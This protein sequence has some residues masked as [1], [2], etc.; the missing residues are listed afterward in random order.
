[1]GD[2]Y[3]LQSSAFETY[4]EKRE[5]FSNAVALV[6]TALCFFKDAFSDAEFHN[7]ARVNW[8]V[9]LGPFLQDLAVIY[10]DRIHRFKRDLSPDFDN[11]RE[12]DDDYAAFDLSV[13]SLNFNRNLDRV[14][15][16]TRTWEGSS[17]D[18]QWNKPNG[19]QGGQAFILP[20]PIYD[21]ESNS[22]RQLPVL[23]E[24]WASKVK[25]YLAQFF[26]WII[27]DPIAVYDTNSLGRI[28][29][30]WVFYFSRGT[31]IPFSWLEALITPLPRLKV[32]PNEIRARLL[33][34][35]D[36]SEQFSKRFLVLAICLLPKSYLEDYSYRRRELAALCD[37][38]PTA[39][40]VDGRHY[41]DD[42]LKI[43]MARWSTAGT[44]LLIGQHGMLD[45]LEEFVSLTH[46]DL[47]IANRYFT[48]GT[49]SPNNRNAIGW[50]S[51]R[52]SRTLKK[53]TRKNI[54]KSKILYV[55]RSI[56]SVQRGT[57]WDTPM[58]SERLRSGRHRICELL[59]GD[60]IGDWLVRPRGGDIWGDGANSVASFE[61]YGFDIDSTTEVAEAFSSARLV[62]FE[63]ISTGFA[64]CLACDVPTILF[65]HR[66]T[67]EEFEGYEGEKAAFFRILE[68]SGLVIYNAEDLIALSKLDSYEWWNEP[69]RI[70]IR[71]QIA[72][73]YAR[74]RLDYPFAISDLI[75]SA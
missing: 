30:I 2:D 24:R 26:F 63:S 39:F 36:N 17:T 58:D 11:L 31:L 61:E 51:T 53:M 19:G 10:L 6:E 14:L 54:I 12:P 29:R 20:N 27:R 68:T 28:D 9:I 66:K 13:S 46:H 69:H 7:D 32:S 25:R 47:S 35:L 57:I 33:Q 3:R 52:A 40:F 16:L 37:L 67:R 55:C 48:W 73:R 50:I 56:G 21:S 1:M 18:R 22:V 75:L 8:Q 70:E 43:T 38:K 44:K 49:Y 74:V 65:F 72:E 71:K 41:N 34:R 23:K 64:E 5:A 59:D 15:R 62:I 42:N 4:D 60:E 45:C